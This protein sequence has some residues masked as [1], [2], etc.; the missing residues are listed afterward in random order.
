MLKNLLSH[1]ISGRG[2]AMVHISM[3]S[4]Q[5]CFQKTVL[6]FGK[7]SVTILNPRLGFLIN[8]RSFVLD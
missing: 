4:G 3:S 2:N 5:Y 7:N 1:L 6:P 8:P